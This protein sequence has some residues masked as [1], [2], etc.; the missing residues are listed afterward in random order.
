MNH[1][2]Q[3]QPPANVGA[4]ELNHVH[5]QRLRVAVQAARAGAR[6]CFRINQ[7]EPATVVW[8][9]AA[10]PRVAHVIARVYGQRQQWMAAVLAAFYAETEG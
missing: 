10:A 5:L 8:Y 2:H 1:T 9:E 4:V 7:G 3:L 6:V